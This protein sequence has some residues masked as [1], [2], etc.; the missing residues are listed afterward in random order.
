MGIFRVIYLAE[1]CK[2]CATAGIECLHQKL[3]LPKWKPQILTEKMAQ[4]VKDRSVN[5]REA[6]GKI[7][8]SRDFLFKKPWIK[9]FDLRIP[10]RFVN[11]CQ[12]IHCAIDPAGGGEG[13]DYVIGSMAYEDSKKVVK[14]LQLIN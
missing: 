8:S 13:S 6:K 12:V 14:F 1:D 5:E 2:A 3:S 4:F 7:S 11:N 9:A 10:H